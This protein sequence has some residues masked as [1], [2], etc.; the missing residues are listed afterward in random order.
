[1]WLRDS[2][3]QLQ[4]YVDFLKPDSGN[5]SKDSLASLYRGAINLQARYLQT[6]PYC[7]SFQPPPESGIAPSMNGAANGDKVFPPYSAKDVFECKFELDSLAAFLEL[8]NNYWNKTQ[9]ATF[10]KS[11]QWESAVQ[12]VLNV[13]D[14]MLVPTYSQNG[15]VNV[16]PYTFI[17]TTTTSE[18][19]LDNTGVGNPVQSG[20]GLVRSA[21]RPSDDACIYQ[22][23]IPA[24]AMFSH[25]LDETSA[26]ASA[27]GNAR[28][29]AQMADLS[30]SIRA[31]IFSTGL[32]HD[33][34][35]GTLY[36]FEVDGYGGINSMDDANIP[37][38]LSL[39]FL[40][41]TDASDTVYQATRKKI[42][43]ADNPYFARGPV[44]NAV[45]GPHDGPGH[46]WPMASIVR[47]LTSSDDDEIF[48]TL[49]EIVSSTAGLGLIHESINAFDENNWTRQWFA[50]ANGL[51]GQMILDLSKRKPEILSRS[52]Q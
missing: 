17:R 52:F 12:T 11:F 4:S 22:L 13:A 24:N 10:F 14:S 16:S 6:A 20:T 40:G 9:D 37:S 32:Y 29:S 48:T 5:S 46:G 25:F 27:I 3:N 2:A 49:K 47:I 51:F 33:T 45:G 39:P 8:S 23:F 15:S 43:S 35:Y 26:I 42:L 36:A 18:D 19:T 41:F 21:F 38:I 28:L 34:K 31:A 30:K 1:M 50:W 44:L 7:Q